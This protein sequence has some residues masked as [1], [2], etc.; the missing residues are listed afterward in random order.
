MTYTFPLLLKEG[1]PDPYSIMLQMLTPAGVVDCFF[2]FRI[3]FSEGFAIIK[4]LVSIP[5]KMR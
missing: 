1:W 5:I 2:E 4:N 3:F